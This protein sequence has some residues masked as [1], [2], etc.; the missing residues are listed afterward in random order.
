M[1]AEPR[2]DG[3]NDASSAGNE[4]L[5]DGSVA[6]LAPAA[7]HGVQHPKP[8]T[9]LGRPG[10]HFAELL[11]GIADDICLEQGALGENALAIVA[12]AEIACRSRP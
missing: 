7:D 3:E 9:A 1:R 12:A 11:R 8:T 4:L 5:L 10:H 2:K 6:L